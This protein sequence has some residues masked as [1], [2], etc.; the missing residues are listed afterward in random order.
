MTTCRVPNATCVVVMG[1]KAVGKSWVADVLERRFD[2]RHLDSD[3]LILDLIAAG[4]VADPAR[5]WLTQVEAALADRLLDCPAVSVE[6][7]GAWDSDWLLIGHLRDRGVTVI[8]VWVS[9]RLEQ[10]LARLEERRTRKIP[11][12]PDKARWYYESATRRAAG[13]PFDLV[14][15]TSRDRDEEALVEAWRSAAANRIRANPTEFADLNAV[16]RELIHGAITVLDDNLVGAYLQGSFA[17]GDA[18]QHSDVDFLIA[19]R[20]PISPGQEA[21]LRALHASFPARPVGWAHHLE[22][23]YPPVDEL[24]TVA[25][26]GKAWLYVDNG[27]SQMEWSTHCNSAV[28]RWILREHGLV[29]TGPEPRT[30]L[31]P[32]SAADLRLQAHADAQRF[33]PML[34]S[35]ADLDNAWTQPYVVATF[36]RFLH[37]L[38]TG[39]VTSKRVAMT[40]ARDALD[41]QWSGLIQQALDDRPDPWERVDQSARPGSVERTRQFASYAE[42]LAAHWPRESAQD[43][44]RTD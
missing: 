16:L 17:L 6:A 19:T 8:T 23:S 27:A 39:R 20:D 40:W 12:S 11:T 36:C 9:A 4:H 26:V 1:P 33:M 28:V 34:A 43:P 31:D 13:Y 29:L 3:A 32:V 22:G 10:S 41:P 15:D 30:L 21:A 7:T 37:T 2:I 5:G 42:A 44:P 24:R 35:W 38:D 14:V 18:D 25:A